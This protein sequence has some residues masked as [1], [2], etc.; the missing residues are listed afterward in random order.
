MQHA[1]PA[2]PQRSVKR[3]IDFRVR[4]VAQEVKDGGNEVAWPD[5]PI[6][7]KGRLLVGLANN[8]STA[9]S[10]TGQGN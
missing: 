6:D 2:D 7:G 8:G 5:D 3:I 4:C 10:A 9:N 1:T